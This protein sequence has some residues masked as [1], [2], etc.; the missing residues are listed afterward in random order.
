MKSNYFLVLIHLLTNSAVASPN[1]LPIFSMNLLVSVN[2]S[3]SG[4]G[5]ADMGYADLQNELI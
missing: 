4:C 5:Y 3:A 2:S 1:M